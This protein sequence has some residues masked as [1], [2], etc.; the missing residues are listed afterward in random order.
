MHLLLVEDDFALGNTLLKLLT[1]VYRTTW[2]RNLAQARQ[3]A[4]LQDYSLILLDL[5]LPDGDGLDW[6][7]ELRGGQAEQPVLI[8]SARD[9]LDDR[10][11]G[12]DTGADDYLV[13]PFEAEELLARIRVLLRRHARQSAPLLQAGELTYDAVTD[14]FFL[15]EQTLTLPPKE[16]QLLAVLIHARDRP[17][18]RSRLLQQI[19]S[20]GNEAESNTLDVHIHALRKLL[21]KARIET[22]RGRGYRLVTLCAS[23]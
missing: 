15:Q 22:L 10:V 13:K 20:F 8:L 4:A 3:Q 11:A 12:L 1:P 9:Q 21:G 14:R 16:H 17:V 5:G 18:S 2:V 19:Y 23:D 6:L 7:Q